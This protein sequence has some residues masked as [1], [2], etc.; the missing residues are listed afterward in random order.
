M[1]ARGAVEVDEDVRAG[2][3]SR[4]ATL[5]RRADRRAHRRV[6]RPRVA[7][8]H[9]SDRR[10][11]SHEIDGLAVFLTGVPFAP[12][13]PRWWC[14]RRRIPDAALADA[15]A[16]YATSGLAFG[17]DLDLGTAR[18]GPRAADASRA[19]AR[20]VAVPRWSVAADGVRRSPGSRGRDHRARAGPVR[21]RRGRATWTS[22]R[23]A[24]SRAHVRAFVGDAV[25][26]DPAQRVFVAA[27][28]GRPVACAETRPRDG[29]LGVFGVATSPRSAAAGSAP[30]SRRTR[31]AT[32]EPRP[33]WPCCG[34]PTWGSASTNGSGS[35]RSPPGRCGTPSGRRRLAVSARRR[36]PRSRDRR[37]AGRAARWCA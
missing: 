12:F 34:R 9:R 10:R 20:G 26:A 28:D 29:M 4:E 7:P 19:R 27:V 13:N 16:L 32:V 18:H 8:P 15:R 25:L 2:R 24:G 17:I 37:A 33:S 36:R 3:A 31:S 22:R 11:R 5:P 35:A 30:R 6:L 14:G 21:A 1:Q 23:S